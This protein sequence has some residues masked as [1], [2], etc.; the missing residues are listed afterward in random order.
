MAYVSYT[1]CVAK[2]DYRN[3]PPEWLQGLA[4]LGTIIATGASPWGWGVAFWIIEDALDYML[5]GKLICLEGDQCA[6]GRIVDFETVDDKSFPENVDNDFS[7]NLLLYPASFEE[8]IGVKWEKSYEQMT[9]EVQ[10]DLISEQPGMPVP[11]GANDTETY[12]PTVRTIEGEDAYAL[13]AWTAGEPVWSV[14][15]PAM[16]T[17]CEGSRIHDMLKILRDLGSLG[18]SKV[19]G[20]KP[21]GLPI[22]KLV[23]TIVAAL[24][25]PVVVAAL[26]AAWFAAEDGNPDD[27]RVDPEAGELSVGDYV[28]I[29]G[30]WVYDAAHSGWNE[31]HP[32]KSIQKLGGRTF[33]PPTTNPQ[34]YVDRVCGLYK[35]VPPGDRDGPEGQPASMTPAQEETWDAQRRPQNRWVL[36]PAVD[37]CDPQGEPEQ[38][39]EWPIPR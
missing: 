33:Y 15:V 24:F 11:Y 10:G 26:V 5:N 3:P 38:P 21:L 8:L 9:N 4:A 30:R 36:H 18:N 22:G 39:P 31:L 35:P 14:S 28:V 12:D 32:V 6:V 34:E 25:W 2:G 37:G 7:I 19:C 23:C 27:A 13:G 16:H 17:E 20:W 1:K 29:K